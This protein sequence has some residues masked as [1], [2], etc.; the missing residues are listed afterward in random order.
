MNIGLYKVCY[1]VCFHDDANDLHAISYEVVNLAKIFASHGDKVSMLSKSDLV[2]GK[3]EGIVNGNLEQRYDRIILVG[4]VFAK[5][6]DQQIVEHLRAVTDRLDFYLTDI[7]CTPQ[8]QHDWEL[9]DNVYTQATRN[10]SF[11]PRDDQQY[12]G[13]SEL[14][15]FGSTPTHEQKDIVY[16]FG[17][18]ERG[19]LGD[20]IEYVWRPDCVWTGKSQFFDIDTRVDRPTYLDVMDRT[21]YSIVIMDTVY[22]NEHFI[23]PRHY[24]HCIRGI[25]SF[26]DAKCDPDEHLMKHNDFRRVNNYFELKNKMNQLE[27]D[28]VFRQAILRNQIAEVPEPFVNGDYV[29]SILK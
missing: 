6:K 13:V 26:M 4:G 19:R 23:T 18:T 20:L 17:G 2:D 11:V 14:A 24:E 3:L 16:S 8:N 10:I 9:F 5:E 7:R 29:Y 28:D 1:E 12:G 22:N 21:K 15:C 27:S 25:V